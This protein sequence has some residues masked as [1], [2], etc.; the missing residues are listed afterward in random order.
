MNFAKQCPQEIKF[1]C[2]AWGIWRQKW[3]I[4]QRTSIIWVFAR[5]IE[6]P[7]TTG[8][9][10]R[11]LLQRNGV[12]SVSS[13]SCL[14]NVLGAGRCTVSPSKAWRKSVQTITAGFHRKSFRKIILASSAPNPSERTCGGITQ[15]SFWK[16]LSSEKF[17]SISTAVCY[18]IDKSLT[19]G[20]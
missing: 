8:Q 6:R 10:V 1:C 13:I 14:Q 16:T 12:S 17:C 18:K 9:E 4:R 7:F 11:Q 5:S 20:F 3:N 15:H 19:F 2:S